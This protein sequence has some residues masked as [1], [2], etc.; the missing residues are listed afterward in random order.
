MAGR[1][2]GSPVAGASLLDRLPLL[3]KL[4]GDGIEAISE[5]RRRRPVGEDVAEMPVAARAANLGPH[6]AV[7]AIVDLADMIGVEGLGE[8]GP[9]GAALELAAGAEERE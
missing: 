5:P 3:E 1:H 9:A 2:S 4:Q 8:A 7:A 6:H